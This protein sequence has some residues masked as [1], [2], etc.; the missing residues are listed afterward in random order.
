MTV[1]C[2]LGSLKEGKVRVRLF[3]MLSGRCRKFKVVF[4]AEVYA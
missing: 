3:L 4:C 2:I 1:L